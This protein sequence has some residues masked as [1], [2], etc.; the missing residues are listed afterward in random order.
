ML[1]T[2]ANVIPIKFSIVTVCYNAKAT[3]ERT[4][5][6]VILQTFNN[7]E[8][9]IIDGKSTDGTLDIINK[10]RDHINVILSETDNGIYDAMNKGILLS[11]GEYI[12]FMNSGDTFVDN[13]VL[14]ELNNSIYNSNYDVVFGDEIKCYRWGQILRK[15]HYLSEKSLSMPFGH[16]S[17]F[18][19]TKLMKEKL[20]D[21]SF[22]ILSDQ[23]SIFS[24]YKDGK[25]FL[26]VEF[27][28]ARYDMY[29]ASNN[30][31][32]IFKEGARINNISGYSYYAGYIKAMIKSSL[33]RIT[34]CIIMDLIQKNRYRQFLIER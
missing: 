6:S 28:I 1:Q 16:Q 18:V 13:N 29:G 12:N 15:A 19:K 10:Y 23:N 11:S 4:I 14:N 32:L 34:P 30:I 31:P 17:T 26:N 22:K 2:R 8:Y 21:T 33:Y 25:S 24:Y 9:I 3:I 20:F 5:K 27:P 7:F